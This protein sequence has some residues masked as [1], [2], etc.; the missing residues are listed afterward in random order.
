M[1]PLIVIKRRFNALRALRQ[2]AFLASLNAREAHEAESTDIDLVDSDFKG[3]VSAAREFEILDGAVRE[4]RELIIN[5]YGP[6]Y[7][8][9]VYDLN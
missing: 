8:E 3:S 2:E 9:S 6:Q 5:N 7:L 4:M 1:T